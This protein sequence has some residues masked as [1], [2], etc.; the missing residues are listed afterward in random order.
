MLNFRDLAISNEKFVNK[1][2][3]HMNLEDYNQ[4]KKKVLLLTERAPYKSKVLLN[5][6]K[7][8]SYIKGTLSISSFSKN[9]VTKN[10]GSSPVVIYN[11][12]EEIIDYQLLE[13]KRNR[14]KSPMN[15]SASYKKV[16][17]QI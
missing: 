6:V 10:T 9:F 14:F 5:F 17:T 7:Y 16:R 15:N 8:P 11:Q 12:L 13:W 1:F 2:G 3:I 4:I